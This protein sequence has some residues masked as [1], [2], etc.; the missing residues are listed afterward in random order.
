MLEDKIMT[1]KRF[2]EAVETLVAKE[3]MSYI[4]AMTY[5]VEYRKLDFRNVPKLM[6]DSLKQKVEAEAKR[7]NLL[8]EK[9]GN[10][11]PV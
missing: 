1:K 7:N 11:L 4:D 3:D 6:T 2:S 9:K 10:T 5:F 8:R